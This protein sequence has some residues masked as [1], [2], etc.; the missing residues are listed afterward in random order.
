MRA[1]YV[2]GLIALI[3]FSYQKVSAY[4]LNDNRMSV[5]Q[6]KEAIQEKGI[7]LV[8]VR[9]VSEYKGGHI[10]TAKNIDVLA[11]QFKEKISTLD[12]SK[13]TY[14]YCRSGQR[15]QKAL[16]IMMNNGFKNIYD[17]K[18]GYLAWKSADN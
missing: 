6:F 11:N 14:I 3:W 4:Q 15:S 2:V 7:Q 12:K 9:T 8:D 1:I 5:V 16:K 10:K 13:P 17:L 18:G